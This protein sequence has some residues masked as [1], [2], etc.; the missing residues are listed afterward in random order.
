MLISGG[1][2]YPRATPQMWPDLIAKSKE[3][4]VDV[5]ES[6]TFWNGHE[7]VRGHYYFEGRYDLV[8]FVKLVGDSG[9]YFIL[10]IGPY[11]CAEWNFGGF[12]VWL[13]DVPGIEFR[14]DNE[15]FKREMQRYV[16]MIVDLLQE[17]KLFSWQGGPIILLQIE[18]EY[19]NM[20]SSYGQKGKDYVKWAA[21]MALGLRAGVP[22]LMCKQ[23]DAPGDIIDTC[24]A[25][26][27]DGYKPNSPNKPT[28]WT[29]NWDGW[30]TSWG[31]R[32]PH[33]PVEDLAFAVARLRSEPKWGH[34]K[35]LHAA[36]RLCER[37]LVAA[38]SP[39]YMKLGP[40]QEAHV[41]WENTQTSG[42]NTT[43]SE[44]QSACSAFLANID[45]HKVATVAFHGKSYS[46]PPW[47]VSILPDCRNTAFNT[48]K[49]GAQTSMK[50][51][52]RA[53]SPKIYVP[54][55]VMTKNEVSS[56]SGSW[57]S[58]NEPV[59]IWSVNNFTFKCMLEHL[60]VTKDKSDYLWR[61]T[62]IYVSDEDIA[63]WEENQVSPTLVIDSMR[64]VLRVFINGE[65]I[66]SIS[67]HWVKVLQPV[68]FRQGYSDLILLSQ[69]V[70]L[71]N[72]GA[73]LEKDGAGFR[74]QIKLTGFKNGDIDLSKASWSYQV[75]LKG[76]FQK[77]FTI[78]ENEKAG[79]TELQL[80]ATPST[81]TWYKA[82]FDTPDGTEPVA[83][84]LG[85]M[86][87]GQAWVNG[88]H[89]GRYWNLIAP[90]DKCPKSC[91]Y[92]GAYNS[93]KCMTNCGKPTQTWY[94]VPRS[95]LQASNN[96]LVIFEETGGNPF[97]IS[98]K[99]RVPRYLCAQ[100]SES[101]YPPLWQWL[102]RDVFDGKVSINDMRPEIHLQ[103]EDGHIISSIEFAS[104]GTPQGS[105][106]NFSKGNCHSPNSLSVVSKSCEGRNS[107]FIEVSNSG[108]GGDPCRGVI[109]TL[110][111]QARCVSSSTIG[112]SQF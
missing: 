36:I 109:K 106:Q 63:F 67:G 37:A 1:I 66:G 32:L 34:L 79:W 60:N 61:M 62:R 90:K 53:L 102:H 84:D 26:Y 52:E 112:V 69:T 49:V 71:Q 20:E 98:V 80:D 19:G 73:F 72:S 70:G 111:I 3:G 88:H 46:L 55:L 83:L 14:T 13:R 47:S 57:M 2:H 16:T 12:P 21:N 44:S 76:E 103:C 9:L 30:Y 86:G 18:N 7:P 38:D 43:L 31:G 87:K 95:W 78:E 107:C 40:K 97:G 58:V 89:I 77:I 6:Y 51:V 96:L 65:L 11:V 39:Q 108:F 29:E 4:G 75:G 10:R 42:L 74:G 105:C 33:R 35:D 17:E 64:D 81:F 41:Y 110:A 27:C 104:Y 56:I 100:V 101:H 59:G 8:K 54:E 25:Y 68:Q 5:I 48:A 85:S 28:I 94:H 24:N 22:W 15:P 92:R 23:T 45:E 50:L 93:N 91:D 82:Y 99:L